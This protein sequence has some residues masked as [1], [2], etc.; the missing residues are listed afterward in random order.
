MTDHVAQPAAAVV[1]DP[2]VVIG[3]LSAITDDTPLYHWS[4][5]DRRESIQQR[6][7]RTRQPS[8]QGGQFRL[9]FV[10]LGL[11]PIG[12]WQMSAGSFGNPES[13]WDLWMT[14]VGTFRSGAL[15]EVLP[16][17]DGTPKEVRHYGM[18]R[19]VVYVATR[20]VAPA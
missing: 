4:P 3:D 5:T 15:Y 14:R 16:Y 13:S 9:P 8:P 6:G 17:D 19:D 1:A 11:D 18:V 12:A 7:L 20:T 10:A 2:D